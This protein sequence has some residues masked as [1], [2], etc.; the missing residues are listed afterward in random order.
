MYSKKSADKPLAGMRVNLKDN[1]RLAGIKTTMTNR[2]FTELY[3]A[4]KESAE[5]VLRLIELGAVVVG[6]SRMA[7]F[8]A[9][10]EPTDQWVDFHCPF[11]PRADMYQSPGSSSS[12]AGAS[13]AG[14]PWLDFALG[15]DSSSLIPIATKT[16]D[17]TNSQRREASESQQ[18]IMDFTDFDPPSEFR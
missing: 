9:G 17:L 7:S 16:I 8:A 4:E 2:A 1:F 18:Q 13:L 10:E 5:V 15:T 3:T 6:K 12:G 14:Y 11:N